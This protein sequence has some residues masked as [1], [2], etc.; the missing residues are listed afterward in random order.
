VSTKSF[1]KHHRQMI[2][3]TAVVE[4]AMA[5][6]R[7]VIALKQQAANVAAAAGVATRG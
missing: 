7:Q 2:S 5:I 4:D 6:G 3:K 1:K